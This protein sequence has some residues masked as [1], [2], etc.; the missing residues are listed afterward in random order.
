[1][2]S[3]TAQRSIV[4]VGS[5]GTIAARGTSKKYNSGVKSIRELTD[6]LSLAYQ[7]IRPTDYHPPAAQVG[8]P[9]QVP[10]SFEIPSVEVFFCHSSF[11][12]DA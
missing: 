3:Q 9:T 5:G 7:D 6:R 4:V 1:M 10:A 2:A 12:V 8:L 11:P